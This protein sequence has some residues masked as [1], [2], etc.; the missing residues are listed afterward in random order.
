MNRYLILVIVMYISSCSNNDLKYDIYNSDFHSRSYIKNNMEVVF[1]DE[2]GW[3]SHR[4]DTTLYYMGGPDMKYLTKNW[5][6]REQ[7]D[8]ED[9][10]RSM[11]VVDKRQFIVTINPLGDG[12]CEYFITM[13]PE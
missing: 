1:T 3:K 7:C 4:G 10:E 13:L 9:E 11:N 6:Y 8:I 12:V 5:G 2:M